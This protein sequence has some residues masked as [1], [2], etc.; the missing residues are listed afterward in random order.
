MV[1]GCHLSL[2]NNSQHKAA[3]LFPA[4]ALVTFSLPFVMST[5]HIL[6]F[7]PEGTGTDTVASE[8]V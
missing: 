5:S 2:Q 3:V 8:R 6:P 7:V 1:K 4:T